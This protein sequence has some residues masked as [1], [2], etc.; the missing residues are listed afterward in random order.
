M[1][2]PW[3]EHYDPGIPRSIGSYPEKTLV[4]VLRERVQEE[5]AAVALVFKGRKISVAE[6]D[7][8][9]DALA[10]SL[11]RLGVKHG[12]RVALVLPNAPQ[13]VIC[14]FAA[15]KIG[16]IVAPQNP[17][18]TDRELEESLG[19]SQPET[20]VTLT[21]FY[22]RVKR[23]QRPTGLKRVIATNIKEYFPPALRILFT[24]FKEKKSGHRIA[25]GPDDLWLADL[26]RQGERRGPFPS[27]A[28]P[29]DDA[30]ILMSG[31]TT[32]TPKGAV[33]DHRSLV[34]TGT[35]IST[36]LHEPLQ[37]GDAIMLPL[38]LFHSYGAA[39]VLPAT[40]LARV[41]LIL[42][43]NP[44]DIADL[45]VTIERDKPS[46]FCGVPALFIAMLAHPKVA[47]KKV[48]FTSI[49][50][51]FSGAAPLLAETKKRFEE[52][53]GGR[54][55]EAYSLTEATL[56][57]CINPY[58]GPNKIGSVGMPL[59]DVDVTVVDADDATRELPIGET[60]EIVIRAP[61]L[62][63]RYWNNP[64]ETE[65][66]LRRGADGSLSLFTG[67]LGYLDQDGYLFIVDRKKDLIKTSG[68][69]VWP[70]E[71]EEVIATH[72][73]VAEVGVAGVP[74]ARKGEV[75]MAWVVP[76]GDAPLTESDVRDFCRDK[77][78]PYKIPARVEIRKELPKTLV[79]K[80]LRRALVAE[81]K[82]QMA[83]A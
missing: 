25:I 33:S 50:A 77:L 17:L 38:P 41:P 74:D 59:P 62:M 53:T 72:P 57:L 8:A 60:G 19:A 9:S 49:K 36:W 13:F 16:A 73:K 79:G 47:A 18:Y 23:C 24:L 11:A 4:D 55:I 44:R 68:Y 46:V 63:R 40:M 2:A 28:K 45:V 3:L 43:P 67:D 29:A 20:A 71:I 5:P 12:D 83:G 66:V 7:R 80:V 42:V 27:Q 54:I 22:E 34:I 10:H 69:Q 15:W 35:Q 81:V 21:P 37:D 65:L 61:Q 56:A 78:A 58:R 32:G 52:I 39:G 51:S 82:E 1:S 76:R 70:R 30:L 64:Q 75:V 26:I 31:G 14:Q 48:D 6:I